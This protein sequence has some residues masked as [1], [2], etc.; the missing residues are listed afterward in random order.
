MPQSPEGGADGAGA[1]SLRSGDK[2]ARVLHIP[3]AP[4]L[5]AA[6]WV[7]LI[8][9]EREDGNEVEQDAEQGSENP[10]AEAEEVE[11]RFG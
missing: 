9:G 8:V 1:A 11:V 7:S 10:A 6:E 2:V 3:R 4:P 5:G